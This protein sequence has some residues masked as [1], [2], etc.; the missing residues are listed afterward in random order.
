[1]SIEETGGLH[2]PA[3]Y[4][5]G[6]RARGG[7]PL[8]EDLDETGGAEVLEITEEAGRGLGYARCLLGEYQ[9]R[10]GRYFLEV[11]ELGFLSVAKAV[12]GGNRTVVVGSIR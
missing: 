4:L 10:F 11:S 9:R 8:E 3:G 12:A 1:M 6:I 2:S 5:I 7:T